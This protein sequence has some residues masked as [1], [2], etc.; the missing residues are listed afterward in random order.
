MI[1]RMALDLLL[2]LLLPA[3]CAGCDARGDVLCVR[4]GG[5]LDGPYEVRR[6]ATAHGPPVYALA[7]YAGA[8]RTLVLAY[9]ERGRRDLAAPLGRMMAGVL[10]WLRGAR[11]AEDGTWWLV[12]APSRARASRERGGAHLLRLARATAEALSRGGQPAAVAPALVLSA[13]VA[14]SVG[15]AGPQ[16]A[17]NLAGRVRV[18]PAGAPPPGTPVVLLDDVVTTGST[19][20]ACVAALAAAGLSV[21]ASLVLTATG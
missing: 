20:A 16:R 13:G 10:P 18:R 9:K 21:G 6:A 7:D 2:D 12:P 15:L 11:P 5:M 17:A 14:D 1:D 19:M 4:C 8:A 3:R